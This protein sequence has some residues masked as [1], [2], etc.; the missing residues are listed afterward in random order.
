MNGCSGV[1]SG[2]IPAH[3]PSRRLLRTITREGVERTSNRLAAI[4]EHRRPV[5]DEYAVDPKIP[6]SFKRRGERGHVSGRRRRLYAQAV[7]GADETL[8]HYQ[9]LLRNDMERH[10]P[11][12]YTVEFESLHARGSALSSGNSPMRAR[13]R[14]CIQT[15]AAYLAATAR[16]LRS[17]H[18]AVTST[19][20]GRPDSETA[21]SNGC[22]AAKSRS[23]RTSG[24]MNTKESGDRHVAKATSSGQPGFGVQAGCG[25]IHLV[26]ASLRTILSTA[27]SAVSRRWPNGF[28]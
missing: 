15:A 12:V 9:R 5:G 17:C 16:R 6:Q 1:R 2:D 20:A 25:A 7:P 23:S 18:G 11:F 8:S 24:S 4:C 27:S 22:H 10:L 28:W 13:P 19:T 26:S 14:G 21:R 3:W